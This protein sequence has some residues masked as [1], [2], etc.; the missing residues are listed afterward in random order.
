MCWICL[1]VFGVASGWLVCRSDRA[2]WR[3][4]AVGGV[5]WAFRV[6]RCVKV[7]VSGVVCGVVG[8]VIR[9]VAHGGDVCE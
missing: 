3:G 7:R 8:G 5:S 9:D 6:R 1:V 4:R 2:C